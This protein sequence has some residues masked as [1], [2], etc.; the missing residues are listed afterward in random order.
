LPTLLTVFDNHAAGSRTTEQGLDRK[1]RG[2]GH[3][4]GGEKNAPARG[5]AW[6]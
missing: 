3:D 2:N 5:V 1:T 6:R 4:I